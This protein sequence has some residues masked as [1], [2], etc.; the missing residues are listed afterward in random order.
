[1]H[2]VEATLDPHSS[3]AGRT[4][5]DV[6]FRQRLQLELVAIWRNG[7]PLRTELGQ[8]KLS[9]G[10]ALLLLGPRERLSLLSNDPDLIVLTPI[11]A[12]QIDTSKAPLA[13]GLMI[14]VIGA[15]LIGWLPIAI[16]AI[17]GATL[18]VLTKCLTM[19]AAYRAIE[20]RSI[21]LIA[22]MLPLGIAME[23]SGAASLVAENVM[24][25]LGGSG[26]WEVIA[27]LYGI[28]AIATMIVPTAA[29][30]LLMAPIVL[31]AS[32]EL[33]IEPYAPMMAIALAASAS[34][35]SPISHPANVLVMG[36][37][38]YRFVDYLKLGVPLTI[39]VFLIVAVFLPWLW[40]LQM[41]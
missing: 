7:R 35:T 10:D 33:G 14:G 37:G 19:E 3:L 2:L 24:R 17:L 26:P 22:G 15:V 30:V 21:F 32:T 40:P 1:M 36:P 20:W 23:R 4:V 5:D 39:V 34:F 25:A 18:M 16:A 41:T 27:G 12:P 29:L 31:S 8:L 38:G 11:T 28:T 13:A 6:N 9:L